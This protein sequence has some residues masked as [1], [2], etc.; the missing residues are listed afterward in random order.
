MHVKSQIRIIG[1]DDGPFKK[2]SKRCIVIGCAFRG[3]EQIDGV[4]KTSI[5]VDGL[6]ATEKFIKLL[7]NSKFKDAR[8]I[9]LD[10]ITFGG[11]NI[12]NIKEL[13]EVTNLPVIA[14]NRKKPDIKEF[15]KAM[16]KLPNFSE[17][18]RAVKD[19]GKIYAMKIEQ[20]DKK[21]KIYFQKSGISINDTEK[22]INITIKTSLFPEP[23]R[24]AHLIATGVVLGQSIGRA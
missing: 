21:G 12:V 19:A 4:L 16:K 5:K 20:G 10:G 6:D 18:K 8:I 22:I 1:I 2:G 7:N 23:V 17:R 11:F 24:V 14:V 15:M 3:S 9:M 13:Y